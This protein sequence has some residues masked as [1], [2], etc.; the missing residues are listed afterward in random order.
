MEFNFWQKQTV[1]HLKACKL[2][3][4]IEFALAEDAS[5]DDKAKDSLALSQI[6]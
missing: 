6:H 2:H 3:R 1:T 5:E 4:Y